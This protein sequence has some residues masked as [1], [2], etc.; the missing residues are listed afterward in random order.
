[1]ATLK[2]AVLG[3]L[4]T[5]L[6]YDGTD[7]YAIKCDTDGHL[8]IDVLS[9]ALPM[10]AATDE[11]L[12]AVRDRIGALT[13]P[14][15]GSVNYQLDTLYDLLRLKNLGLYAS[16]YSGGATG[17][18]DSGSVIADLPAI[19]ADKIAVL[20]AAGAIL[21]TGS[22]SFIQLAVSDGTNVRPFQRVL[23]PAVGQFITAPTHL[24]IPPG[25]FLR[26]SLGTVGA[27]SSIT[28]YATGYYVK[29]TD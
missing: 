12:Q 14:A 22:A 28:V 4:L 13:S 1:M 11:V 26:G 6:G 7:F 20:T 2:T 9:T 19:A 29:G 16:G 27:G 25:G 8:Q 5:L 10:G 3:A 15:A 17:T 24:V 21:N 23:A 18:G